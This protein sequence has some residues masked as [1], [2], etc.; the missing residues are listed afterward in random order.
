MG[1]IRGGDI[2]QI[3][4]AGREYDPAS[5]GSMNYRLSGYNNENLPTGNGNVHTNKN[6]KLGGFDGLSISLDSSR[7][8]LESLQEVWNNGVAVPVQIT[9]SDGI[10]YS[11]SLVPEGE[12]PAVSGDGT[13]EIAMLGKK[14]EQQ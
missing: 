11:G 8:D 6:R 10:V 12:L 5:E 3:L 7:L 13:L 9:K 4:I 1:N 2:Q 14:F